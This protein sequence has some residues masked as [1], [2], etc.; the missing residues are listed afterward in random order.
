MELSD[1]EKGILIL[2]ARD[3]IHSLFGEKISP[4]L[5]YN[6]YPGLGQVGP[7]AFVTLTVKNKLR[8]CIGYIESKMTLLDT[9][10]EAAKQAATNDPR[11]YPLSEDEFPRINIEISILS[12]LT[13]I[14]SYQ[15]IEIGKHGLVLDT[16]YNRALLLPQVAKENNYNLQQFLSALCEKAGIDTYAWETD[17]LDIKTFTAIVF[18]EEGKRKRTHEQN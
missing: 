9:V 15:Q 8:G 5:D 14:S 2:S 4:I 1:E 13:P 17:F 12:P 7:G 18:S 3:A 6:Y 11:F 16:E 10:C